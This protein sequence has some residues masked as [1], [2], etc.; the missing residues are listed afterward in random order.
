MSSERMMILNMVSDGKLTVDEASLLL[1]SIARLEVNDSASGE[2]STIEVEP[3]T[4]PEPV[5]DTGPEIVIPPEQASPLF[6]DQ[7]PSKRNVWEAV[8]RYIQRF[9]Q[10]HPS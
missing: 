2:E 4:Q 10:P 6:E 9:R 5:S 1:E 7:T 3:E 8:K